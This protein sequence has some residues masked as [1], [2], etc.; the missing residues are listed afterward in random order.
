MAVVKT[1]KKGIIK[2]SQEAFEDI[3]EQFNVDYHIKNNYIE[4]KTPYE[5]KTMYSEEV[6]IE[7]TD[8]EFLTLAKMAHERDMTFNELCN[9]LLRDFVEN[10]EEQFDNEMVLSSNN[11]A[12]EI[13]FNG[14]VEEIVDYLP[15]HS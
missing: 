8:Q 7:I 4:F 14:E 6:E 10:A 2:I 12:E 9:D 11:I 15:T 13:M 3:L 5:I 1:N